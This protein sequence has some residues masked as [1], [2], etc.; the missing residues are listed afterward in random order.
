[1]RSYGWGLMAGAALASQYLMFQV[2]PQLT[3]PPVYWLMGV[4]ALL[5]HT[6]LWWT[7]DVD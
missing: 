2:N 1:M 3:V 7:E 4:L 6:Y 5:G